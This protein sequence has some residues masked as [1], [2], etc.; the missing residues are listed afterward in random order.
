MTKSKSTIVLL[1]SILFVNS[2]SSQS[3][4]WQEYYSDE[5]IK[6]EYNY[7]N[8]E[9]SSTASQEVVIFRFS[10]LIESSIVINYET[11]IW[12]ED[13]E[14]NTEQNRDEFRKIIKLKK[15]EIITIN[16][17]NKWKEYCIFSGF[18]NNDTNEKYISL[19][20]FELIN[21]KTENE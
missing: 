12:H 8:C 5:K 20:K 19:T 9:F 4:N 18:V 14:I 6:I 11:R 2:L 10:N 15:N 3:N 16:C 13:K 17:E 1:F 21:I 7:M